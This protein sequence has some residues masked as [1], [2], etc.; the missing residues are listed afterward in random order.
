MLQLLLASLIEVVKTKENE[1]AK[2]IDEVLSSFDLCVT[3]L[4]AA[5]TG[6]GQQFEMTTQLVERAS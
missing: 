5:N 6:S 4:G 3:L 1:V 2:L